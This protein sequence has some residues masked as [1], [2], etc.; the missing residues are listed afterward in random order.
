MQNSKY[1][2]P[3]IRPLTYLVLLVRAEDLTEG[4]VRLGL[5][6]KALLNGCDVHDRVVE[7]RLLVTK[8]RSTRKKRGKVNKMAKG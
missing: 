7:L 5:V 2:L 1:F 3:S 8:K 4:L 6:T